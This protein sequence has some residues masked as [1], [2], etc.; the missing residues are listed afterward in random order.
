[1]KRII[2]LLIFVGTVASLASCSNYKYMSENDVYS[3]RQTD[4]IIG[5]SETDLTSFNAYKAREK[6]AFQDS[7]VDNNRSN[8]RSSFG[9]MNMGFGIGA[10]PFGMGYG[11]NNGP[12]AFHG[13]GMYDP[14]YRGN[15]FSQGF[16]AGY[17]YGMY[18]GYNPYDPFYG[19]YYD[20]FYYSGYYNPYSYGGSYYGYGGYYNPYYGNHYGG[21]Y[22][23]YYSNGGHYGG[24]Y[25]GGGYPGYNNGGYTAGGN[26]STT[27][28]GKRN[29]LT[30]GSSRSSSYEGTTQGAPK[31][32]SSIATVGSP[33]ATEMRRGIQGEKVKVEGNNFVTSTRSLDN[34]RTSGS[35]KSNSSAIN[36]GVSTDGRINSSSSSSGVRRNTTPINSNS[37]VV[38][39]STNQRGTTINNGSYTPNTSLRRSGGVRTNSGTINS[40]TTRP[41]STI[42]RGSSGTNN[43]NINRS[44][45]T[46]S[47]PS[48]SNNRSFS[49]GGS[50][51][52]ISSPSSS[53]SRSNGGG[54][55]GNSGRR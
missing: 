9:G 12:M 34:S 29:S 26:T 45:S 2:G 16:N 18:G 41:N 15:S 36:R 14:F 5:E 35:V 39:P 50:N 20:P 47:T 1:M 30:S 55:S 10:A 53:P 38:S 24:G 46:I 21:Y 19:G 17:A 49:T 3:S 22:D 11:L 52:S 40:N 42:N 25:Y 31:L 44:R 51:R 13:M 37:R 33:G 32:G 7:Y 23:P 4:V 6:G 43:S 28:Y 48:P 8:Q 54:Q 27:F